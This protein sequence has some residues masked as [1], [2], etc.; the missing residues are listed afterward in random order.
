VKPASPQDQPTPGR[1]QAPGKQAGEAREQDR[2]DVV[3]YVTL[4]GLQ[5]TTIVSPPTIA[6]MSPGVTGEL[7]APNTLFNLTGML[8]I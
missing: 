5:G 2:R 6:G 1:K 7:P 4:S 8:C 3:D